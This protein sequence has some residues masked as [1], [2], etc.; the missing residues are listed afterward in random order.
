M[1][2][3]RFPTREAMLSYLLGEILKA[4]TEMQQT[5]FIDH[6]QEAHEDHADPKRAKT[7]DH[8]RRASLRKLIG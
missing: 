6:P 7:Q 8:P 2:L 1:I 3:H 5:T 4:R